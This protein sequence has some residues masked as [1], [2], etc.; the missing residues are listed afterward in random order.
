MGVRIHFSART[1][2]PPAS[3]TFG[4]DVFPGMRAHHPDCGAHLSSPELLFNSDKI[5][6]TVCWV[7]LAQRRFH[8]YV[9]TGLRRRSKRL[10]R[11]HF[12]PECAAW[13]YVI[14]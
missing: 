5:E 1:L 3:R 7:L 8:N 9:L 4:L 10:N 14:L 13:V 11:T 12:S 2:L 6:G